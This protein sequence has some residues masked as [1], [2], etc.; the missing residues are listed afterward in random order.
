MSIAYTGG[1]LKHIIPLTN[2]R[3]ANA[4]I[5]FELD[6]IELNRVASGQLRSQE[7]KITWIGRGS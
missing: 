6:Q 3:N 4:R 2:I 5:K 7:N 1:M